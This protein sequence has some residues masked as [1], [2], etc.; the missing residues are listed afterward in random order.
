MSASSIAILPF[1]NLSNDPD[2]EYFGD[3]L[4]EEI[5]NALTRVEG[6]L[7]TARTSSFAFKG[8]AVGIQEIGQQLGVAN[9]LE[10]SIR[11][12]AGRVRIT[13]QLV[14][15]ENGYHLWSENFDRLLDDIFVVQDEISLLIADK[16]RENSA[17]FDIADQLVP[18]PEISPAAYQQF[19]RAR[20]LVQRFNVDEVQRGIAMLETLTVEQPRFSLPF[21]MLNYAYTFMGAFGVMPAEDAFARA[22]HYLDQVPEIEVESAE[23]QLRVSGLVYW[24][25]WDTPKALGHLYKAL[26]QQPGNAE[27]HLWIGVCYATLSQFEM[28]QRHLDTAL[29]LD[30]FSPLLH[31]FKGVGY[32]FEERY[33]LAVECFQRCIAIDPNFHMAHINWGAAELMQGKLESGMRRFQNLPPSGQSDLSTLGGVTL[34]HA[35][36]GNELQT[37][38]GI[39]QLEAALDSAVGDRAHFFLILTYTH[40]G[41]HEKALDLLEE[42]IERRM[43]MLIALQVE[44]FL[45]TLR[46]TPR[47]QAIMKAVVGQGTPSRIIEQPK[48]SPVST[49][50]MEHLERLME[51]QQ[52]YLDPQLSLRKLAELANY[53]PNYLSRLINE[54]TG[55]NFAEYTNTYRLRAFAHMAQN[56]SKQQLTLLAIAYECGFNSKT[57]FNTFCKK[58]TGMTPSAFWKSL[59]KKS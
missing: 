9:I 54:S 5:I 53:H 34:A 21:L 42:A 30:P 12:A 47:Y 52:P 55:G 16:V 38:A 23:Y 39:R 46:T 3:G 40:L 19:L 36:L 58:R 1:V 51:E 8:R 14:S 28:A 18:V 11:V 15:V 13:A 25:D 35:M 17:H 57:V 49:V 48:I 4:A 6:L 7:V 31:D 33:D 32:Y 59:L 27:I 56:P 43:S 26:Q 22:R 44:P 2:Q 20:Y 24:Q 50:D 10:G 45:K 29:K 41:E 37:M